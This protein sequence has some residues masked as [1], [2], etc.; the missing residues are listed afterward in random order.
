[1]SD[2]R[3]DGSKGIARIVRLETR[4]P[5]SQEMD[6]IPSPEALVTL[7]TELARFENAGPTAPTVNDPAP[8]QARIMGLADMRGTRNGKSP[9][10]MK[11][12]EP[13]S[14]AA[15]QAAVEPFNKRA[16]AKPEP[17]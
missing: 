1:M 3:K 8:T 15:H 10:S 5:A 12:E 13:P 7:A 11:R 14:D 17:K 6:V 9:L 4:R 16:R 2:S